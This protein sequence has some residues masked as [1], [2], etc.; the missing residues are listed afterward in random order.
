MNVMMYLVKEK[1]K[2]RIFGGLGNRSEV[3]VYDLGSFRDL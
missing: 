3:I 2:R 1:N